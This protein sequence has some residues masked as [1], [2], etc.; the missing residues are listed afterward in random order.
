[1]SLLNTT[2]G[3]M[4]S[5]SKQTAYPPT[6]GMSLAHPNFIY[7]AHDPRSASRGL[8]GCLAHCCWQ[9]ILHSC[10][11]MLRWDLLGGTPV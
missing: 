4:F 5:L 9:R 2:T 7:K 6:G 1:M 3:Q 11:A 8:M 10:R